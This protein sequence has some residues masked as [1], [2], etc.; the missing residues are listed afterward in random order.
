MHLALSDLLT[1]PRCGPHHGLVLL[2]DRV[3]ERRVVSGVLGCPNCR[4][5][6]PIEDGTADLR[7]AGTPP[8]AEDAVGDP[9]PE[10]PAGTGPAR[11]EP[12]VRLAA[13]LGLD[14]L[15]GVAV[16]VGPAA[17]H[18][19]AVAGLAPDVEV[20]AAGPGSAGPAT[21]A[22]S[23]MRLGGALPFRDGALAAVAL[24]GEAAVSLLAEALRAL[25]PGGR[26]VLEPAAGQL[27]ERAE[28][29]GAGTLLH[30][31]DT[32]VVTRHR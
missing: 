19:A 16:L 22:V 14:G 15:A 25:R 28:A 6:Y 11:T 17:R 7:A 3:S 10:Q 20:V 24:T 31:R 26:L 5:R 8:P 1:C 29:A 18:A 32:L 4:E 27:R 23:G 30:E 2:P 21:G 13:L 9:I 12:A